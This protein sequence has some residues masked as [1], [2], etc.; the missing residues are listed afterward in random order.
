MTRYIYFK[1]VDVDELQYKVHGGD[2]WSVDVAILFHQLLSFLLQG[3]GS[4][5]F[6]LGFSKEVRAGAEAGA[7][8]AA[9]AAAAEAAAAEAAAAEAAAAAE[10]AAT[11]AAAAA[12][13][14]G[15]G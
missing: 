13:G 11:A 1:K 10:T 9:A 14:A 6:L 15:A 3:H 8:A 4:D 12:A 2:L 7:G 5:F